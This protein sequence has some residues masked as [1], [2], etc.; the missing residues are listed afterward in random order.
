MIPKDEQI[1]VYA[2][3]LPP[4]KTNVLI[5]P[6]KKIDQT[7]DY[8]FSTFSIYPRITKLPKLIKA[9]KK[10][11]VKRDF[12]KEASNFAKFKAETK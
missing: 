2:C 8:W 9:V 5:K 11:E 6:G 7:S 12:D 10:V 4:R 3:W 1:Y